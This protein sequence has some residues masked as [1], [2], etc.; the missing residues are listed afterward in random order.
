MKSSL[1]FKRFS[2]LLFVVWLVLFAL[3]PFILVFIASFLKSNNVAFLSFAFTF[4]NYVKIFQEAYATVLWRSFLLSGMT[5]FC[6]LILGYPFALILSRMTERARLFLLFLLIIPFWTSSLIRIYAMIIII[7]VNGLL[8]HLLIFFGVIHEP[9]HILYTQ[10]AVLVGLVYALLPYMIFPLYA[11]LE[12]FDW[13]LVNAARDLGAGKARTLFKV[14]IPCSI[15]GIVAGLILV[16]LPAMTMFYIP[17]ILGGAK[18]LLL[19]NLI[20]DQFIVS[21]NWPLGSAVSMILTI[22]MTIMIFIY[23][24]VSTEQDRRQIL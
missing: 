16:L 3:V 14:I 21:H 19:G 12:R 20:K 17:D 4:D 6:C 2:I 24:R 13:Q 5:A 9:F 11:N 15:P 18:S 1:I 22:I 23:W 10:T 8:N 7:R